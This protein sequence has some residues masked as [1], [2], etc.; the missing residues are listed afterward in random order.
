MG[1]PQYFP[2]TLVSGTPV[3]VDGVEVQNGDLALVGQ[4]AGL[5]DDR[6]LAEILRLAPNT[7]GTVKAKVILPFDISEVVL[8]PGTVQPSGADGSIL[9]YPF[10]AIVGT[11]T[12]IATNAQTAWQDIR[13][14]TFIPT[15]NATLTQALFLN[16]NTYG[17]TR[18]DLVY[19]AF[20]VD[21]PQNQV[22]RRIK[23]PSQS[24]PSVQAVYQSIGQQL[25]VNVVQGASGGAL[26]ALPSDSGTTYYFAL[27][28]IRIPSTFTT[29]STVLTSD[30][31]DQVPASPLAKSTG[32]STV[33]P[34]SGNNDTAGTYATDAN[35]QWPTTSAA[36]RPSIFLPPSMVGSESIIIEMDYASSSHYSHPNGS[37]ID[38]TVD[39]RGRFFLVY[40]F[41]AVSTI[42]FGN[43]PTVVPGSTFPMPFGNYPLNLSASGQTPDFRMA[44]S[45]TADAVLGAGTSLVYQASSS[46]FPSILSAGALGIYVDMSSG[47]LKSYIHNTPSGVRLFVWLQASAQFP[48]Y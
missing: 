47:A 8:T 46:L 37:I 6:V 18:W 24:T 34:A 14:T 32:A 33:R 38:A 5:A 7:S 3:L 43:D 30:I 21:A 17:S 41:M 12:P 26:P 48:N 23:D 35:F 9:V 27:A 16:P 40:A 13:S 31:R 22:Q 25:T 4:V 29:T 1:Q 42:P 28:Y 10:R 19:A 11:R 15:G 39:W 2:S 36:N 44:N 45:F 20:T